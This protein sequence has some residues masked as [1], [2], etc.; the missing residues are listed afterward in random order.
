MAMLPGRAHLQPRLAAVGVSS[1]EFSPTGVCF[2]LS[3]SEVATEVPFRLM[4]PQP[5]D[6]G[7][8]PSMFHLTVE[9]LW[10]TP[11]ESV[12]TWPLGFEQAK[13]ELA[14][15]W[16]ELHLL[17]HLLEAL[18]SQDGLMWFERAFLGREEL[19]GSLQLSFQNEALE[20]AWRV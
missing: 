11:R 19:D 8:S 4:H 3:S 10:V 1:P 14:V 16:F 15:A 7:Q 9:V 20:P 2:L 13:L 5:D 12:L 17:P 18:S 6:P